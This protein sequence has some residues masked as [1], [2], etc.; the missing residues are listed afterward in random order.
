MNDIIDFFINKKDIFVI[1]E[2]YKEYLFSEI[3][4]VNIFGK[5]IE[6]DTIRIYEEDSIITV[7]FFLKYKAVI[8]LTSG[9]LFRIEVLDIKG[10]VTKLITESFVI[11][12][13]NHDI[14]LF[15][16]NVYMLQNTIHGDVIGVKEPGQTAYVY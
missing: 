6:Y 10:C 16:E 8:L 7:L 13:K 4:H 5:N 11:V 12:D 1:R 9:K 14:A 2:L 3:K 15:L